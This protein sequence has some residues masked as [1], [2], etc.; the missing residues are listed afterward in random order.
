MTVG[1]VFIVFPTL[2]SLYSLAV[3]TFWITTAKTASRCNFF[4]TASKP[5]WFFYNGSLLVLPMS[6]DDRWTMSISDLTQ[7]KNANIKRKVGN[8]LILSLK[9][10][11][12][13]HQ[14]VTNITVTA[15]GIW[16]LKKKYEKN[17]ND[18]GDMKSRDSNLTISGTK[19]NPRW[20]IIN[21]PN[22]KINGSICVRRLYPRKVV[23]Q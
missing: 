1:C 18:W 12:G 3:V 20:N 17:V 4:T 5:L 22:Y 16:N 2:K 6:A 14:K 21:D 15:C 19:N 8:I 9:S 11:I 13:H 7:W 10:W 23:V